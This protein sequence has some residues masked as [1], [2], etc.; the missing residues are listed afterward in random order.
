[1]RT[2]LARTIRALLR[3]PDS[4]E[5]LLGYHSGREWIDVRSADIND[6]LR[7]ISGRQMT[8]KD[9]RTWH[10][11][12]RAA[13]ALAETGPE[14][15]KTGR[16]RAEAQAMREVADLLGNTPAVARSAYVDPKVVAAYERGRTIDNDDP[17]AE[18]QVLDLLG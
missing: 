12:V 7:E 5:E 9:F 8:A 16:R 15:T 6:Y 18:E 1:M 10:G 17:D 13:Q 4:N 2:G 3:R 14:K 11:T